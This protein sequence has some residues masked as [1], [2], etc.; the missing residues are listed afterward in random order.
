[1]V[2]VVVAVVAVVLVAVVVVVAVAV[3][4][5]ALQHILCARCSSTVIIVPDAHSD[6]L[7]VNIHEQ[8]SI[9]VSEFQWPTSRV[10]VV[11]TVLLLL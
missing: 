7:Y 11:V 2:V 3:V 5:V 6:Q 10:F 9:F 1:M 4:A 8:Q